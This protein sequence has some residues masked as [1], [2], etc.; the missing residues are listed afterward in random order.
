MTPKPF[1]PL[2]HFTIHL[3]I[4]I[5]FR[6]HA[7][8][9]RRRAGAARRLIDC[10]GRGLK[11]ARL[12][13]TRR[14]GPVRSAKCRLAP[15]GRESQRRQG[16]RDPPCPNRRRGV[17]RSAAQTDQN[18][19]FAALGFEVDTAQDNAWR[20]TFELPCQ[21]FASRTVFNPIA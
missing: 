11:R 18:F 13:L 2:N 5:S 21:E 17:V 7:R 12:S 19:N 9:G 16:L 15:Y 4:G 10:W 6:V 3:F 14:S 20:S 8:P 1:W